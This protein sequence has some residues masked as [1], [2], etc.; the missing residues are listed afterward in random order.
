MKLPWKKNNTNT[1]TMGSKT[2]GKQSAMLDKWQALP[3]R[4][5]LALGVLFVFLFAFVGVYGSWEL[6]TKAKKQQL[7]F[8]NKV[9][10]LFWLRAQSTNLKE[11]NGQAIAGQSLQQQLIDSIQQA[12]VSAPT[13]VQKNDQL[14]FS[15]Q[16]GSQAI[17]NKVMNQLQSQGYQIVDLEI[18]QDINN[19]SYMIHVRGTIKL[20]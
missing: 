19:Q 11:H 16:H 17:V 5:K 4:D 18:E 14:V 1:P 13:V 3:P 20:S 12:G 8:D 6:H 15:F 2:I 7:A 9:S 10:D